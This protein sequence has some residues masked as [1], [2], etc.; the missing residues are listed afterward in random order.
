[1]N[2]ARFF[3]KKSF[4]FEIQVYFLY[5]MHKSGYKWRRVWIDTVKIKGKEFRFA[6][7]N[8]SRICICISSK[9]I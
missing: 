6:S 1:M 8:I 9:S 4:I 5:R 3:K 7:E 2:L